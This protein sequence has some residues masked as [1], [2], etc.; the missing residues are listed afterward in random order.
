M[1]ECALCD[2]LCLFTETHNQLRSFGR[3]LVFECGFASVQLGAQRCINSCVLSSVL[4]WGWGSV[5]SF[6]LVW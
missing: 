6:M 1:C 2:I 3:V 5:A 4:F